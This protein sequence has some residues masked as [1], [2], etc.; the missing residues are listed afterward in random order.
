MKKRT[1]NYALIMV[2][3]LL[4]V[5]MGS[6][7]TGVVTPA[8]TVIQGFF[9]VDATT[10]IWMIT[11]YTLAYAASIPI[12]GK[13][14]DRH[15]RKPIFLVCIT[16]FGLGSLC[17][18][19][20]EYSDSFYV[21]LACRVLQAIGGGGI[22]PIATAE[23]GTTF[24]PAKRG[25]ALGLVGGVYGVA[26]IIGSSLGSG[27]M[28]LFGTDHW[29]YIFYINVP[30]AVFIIIVG[31]FVLPNHREK[32]E[33]RTDYW[34]AFVLVVIIL[35]LM[36]AVH[37]LDFFDFWSSFT[38]LD[39]WPFI[40]AALALWPLFVF[41]E[42]RADN[43]ILNL[44]YFRNRNICLVLIMS[45]ITGFIMMGMVFVPQFA[46]NVMRLT[47]GQGGYFVLILGL[48]SGIGAPLSGALID[49]VGVKPVIG[50]GF[51]ISL[52]G[53]LFLAYVVISASNL[54][55][56][57]IGLVIAGAGIGLVM[58]TPLNYMMLENT[59][60]RDSNSALATLSLVRSFGTVIAPTI[61]AGFISHAGIAFQDQV[62]DFMPTEVDYTD[63]AYVVH[64]EEELEPFSSVFDLDEMTGGTFSLTEPMTIDM[65]GSGSSLTIP[66]DALA[67]L[68]NSDVTDITENCSYLASILFDEMSAGMEGE[69]AAQLD[70]AITE[71]EQMKTQYA[72][73]ASEAGDASTSMGG[74]SAMDVD[75]LLDALQAVRDNLPDVF[76]TAKENYLTDLAE[77]G[78]TI[79]DAFQATLNDGFQ[80]IYLVITVSAAVGIVCLIPYRSRKRNAPAP[81]TPEA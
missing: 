41:I 42:H 55:A 43:P 75:G 24:P 59:E 35:L 47:S 25:M 71:V 3:Y 29:S 7:D 66:D 45:I 48:V 9:S 40:V 65:S 63:N 4:G 34:G 11:I 20:S 31:I 51:V 76:A 60:E 23:F 14:A 27:I 81:T 39:V 37:D 12:M 72:S 61:M 38:S 62:M 30:I 69:V 8:R 53:G 58:G 57:V 28:D 2:V 5:F 73:M 44:S 52:L 49:K 56:I 17:C 77:N 15:G 21:L 13:L 78:P 1:A 22:M 19:L 70:N 68:E 46:E 80:Q 36:Y 54:I 67:K 32:N 50:A 79:E 64:L 26:N 6:I 10:G 33:A 74:G 18:G 16:L